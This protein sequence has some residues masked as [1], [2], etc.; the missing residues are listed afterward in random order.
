M[1]CEIVNNTYIDRSDYWRTYYK[2]GCRAIRWR[3]RACDCIMNSISELRAVRQKNIPPRIDPRRDSVA[4][5]RLSLPNSFDVSFD[6]EAE[7]IRIADN[8]HTDSVAPSRLVDPGRIELLTSA[9][10]SPLRF[11]CNFVQFVAIGFA[12]RFIAVSVSTYFR[13][14]EVIFAPFLGLVSTKSQQN[15][16]ENI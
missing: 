3:R 5:S 9:L 6:S 15:L 12:M 1:R 13:R 7:K 11:Y 14:S 16:S 2:Q 8:C 10:R 4:P